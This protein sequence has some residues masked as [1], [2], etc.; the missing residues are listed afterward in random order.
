MGHGFGTV[1]GAAGRMNGRREPDGRGVSLLAVAVSTGRLWFIIGSVFHLWPWSYWS[2]PCACHHRESDGTPSCRHTCRWSVG[3][4]PADSQHSR[5]IPRPCST[6][7]P[8]E[9][10]ATSQSH[11]LCIFSF[12]HKTVSYTGLGC[13]AS[14]I[15]KKPFSPHPWLRW[16]IEGLQDGRS[17][18]LKW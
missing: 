13:P 3:L 4:R 12:Q 9:D 14:I 8:W 17:G 16:K 6:H 11:C 5:L 15:T 2:W 1:I 18:C 10:S 7:S